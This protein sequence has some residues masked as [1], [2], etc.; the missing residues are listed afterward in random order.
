M[1]IEWSERANINFCIAQA[2]S[3]CIRMGFYSFFAE[4]WQWLQWNI[5][6][7]YYGNFDDLKLI[8]YNQ[9]SDTVRAIEGCYRNQLWIWTYCKAASLH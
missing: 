7:Y 6:V 2:C 9:S 1:A 4:L 3:G 5:N 8:F